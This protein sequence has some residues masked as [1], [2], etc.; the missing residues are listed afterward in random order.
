M[1]WGRNLTAPIPRNP[2]AKQKCSLGVWSRMYAFQD[3]SMWRIATARPGESVWTSVCSPQYPVLSTLCTLIQLIPAT[4][5][6]LK[7]GLIT[8]VFTHR[9]QR[10]D[11]DIWRGKSQKKGYLLKNFTSWVA[12]FSHTEK[13]SPLTSLRCTPPGVTTE[14]SGMNETVVSHTM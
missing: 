2:E 11:R 5:K 14:A 4:P 9:F 3:S 13:H 10:D 12:V 1:Y 7:S 8:W 6:T